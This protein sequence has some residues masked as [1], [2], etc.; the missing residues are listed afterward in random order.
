MDGA[1]NNTGGGVQKN[2]ISKKNY[3]HKTYIT[4]HLIGTYNLRVACLHFSTFK[5]I[6]LKSASQLSVNFANNKRESLGIY[7][8]LIPY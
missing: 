4:V 7:S 3:L 2:A 1:L 8:P 5:K 6:V